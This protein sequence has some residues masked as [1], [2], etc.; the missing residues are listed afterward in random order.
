MV[1]VGWKERKLGDVAEVFSGFAF[2]SS[3]LKEGDLPVIKIANIQNKQVIQ[4]CDAFFSS[5]KLS[6]KLK[7]YF[8]EKNDFLIAMTGA[9]SVG[10]TGKMRSMKGSF[11]VNQRVGIVRVNKELADPELIFQII[12]Q[13]IFEDRMYQLGLGAGQPNI[14]SNDIKGLEFILPKDLKEQVKI[15]TILSNYD[16][17]I[18]INEKRIKFLEK[19]VKLIYEEWFVNFKFPG[20]EDVKM[21]D[22]KTNFGKIPEN[23]AVKGVKDIEYFTF[24]DTNIKEFTGEKEYFATANISGIDIIKEGEIVTWKNKPSRA[25]KQPKINSVWFARMKDSYKILGVTEANQFIAN[26][27]ILSSGFAGFESEELIFPFLYLTINSERFEDFKD[28]YATGATQVSLN[29]EGLSKIQVIK[30]QKE[31]VEYFGRIT[32]SLI[33]KMF[34]FQQINNKLRKTRDL[35]LPKLISREVD[36]SKLD[37]KIPEI[38]A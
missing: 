6:E 7:K 29:N 31:L 22:S 17:L 37:I 13:D 11:L 35:L 36:V 19:V 28:R 24:I 38:E 18:K 26:N 20:H 10:K 1:K 23:W 27:S 15:A 16:N 14:S 2:K 33:D 30:P 32:K 4:N 12:S 5:K 3:D 9:G 34:Y 25:Q 21:V 8:L